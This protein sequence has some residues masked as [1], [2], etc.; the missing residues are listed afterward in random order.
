MLQAVLGRVLF[1]RRAEMAMATAYWRVVMET[2]RAMGRAALDP[3][4]TLGPDG[5]QG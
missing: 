5:L 3:L 1:G 4:K 2:A